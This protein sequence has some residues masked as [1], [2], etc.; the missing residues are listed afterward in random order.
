MRG[1]IKIL[2]LE[3]DSMDAELIREKLESSDLECLITQVQTRD[4]FS[5]ALH[6][7]G[8][9]LILSDYK[10]PM[11][12]GISAMQMAQEYCPD[13]PFIFVSGT[14]GE[15]AA[16]NTLTRGAT[17][18]VLKTRLNR[19][20]PAVK[21]AFQEI[22]S[23]RENMRLESIM[24][25]RFRIL[26][27]SYTKDLSL[28]ETCILVVD[29]IKALT[30]SEIG[31]FSFIDQARNA[32]VMQ[33][34]STDTTQNSSPID[35][36]NSQDHHSVSG[37]WTDCIN[38]GKPVIRNDYTPLTQTRDL[39]EGQINLFRE[40]L[41]PIIRSNS[42]VAGIGVANKPTDYDETDV[43]VISLLGDFSWELIRRKRL[44][45]EL[46]RSE[47]Q[48]RTLIDTIPDLVW[49][50][51]ADGVY[52]RCNRRF[53]SF[54][55]AKEKDIIGK[56]DYD[57]V[58]RDQADFFRSND[59]AAIIAGKSRMNE[60]KLTFLEDGH[61]EI[62][63]AIKTPVYTSQ[64]KLMGVLGVARDITR[65]IE[66]DQ[67]RLEHLQFFQCMDQIN[68]AMQATN[69]LEKMMINVLERTLSIFECDGASLIYPCDP[70]TE[71]WQVMQ[72]VTRPEYPG[73]GTKTP[74]QMTPDESENLRL[75]LDTDGPVQFGPSAGQVP[76]L[77]A[78][79]QETRTRSALV[80]AVFPKTGKPWQ[81]RIHQCSSER[82]WTSKEQRLFQEIGGRLADCL[83]T[84]LMYREV[85]LLLRE[86]HH[87]TKNIMAVIVSI[88]DIQSRCF[89]DPRWHKSINETKIQIKSIALV[90]QKLYETKELSQ[91]NL[92]DYLSDLIVILKSGYNLPAEHISVS[93]EMDDIF[94]EIDYA[95]PCGLIL[96]ELISNAY[97]YA[98]PG[99]R[100][101]EI[102][103]SLYRNEKGEI[104]LSV[105]DNGV[106][107]PPSFDFRNEA[108]LGIQIIIGLAEYQLG[109]NIR[110]E[111]DQ[112]L[113]CQ[114]IFSDNLYIKRI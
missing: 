28:D 1:H 11:F 33:S 20:A 51:D 95:V 3:D 10:L 77:T 82:I 17:D 67:E 86:L 47:A 56:T 69:D 55:G 65:R 72:E 54:F 37:L 89:S 100:K 36:R 43:Q 52:L 83:S 24:K 41:V 15:D 2:H 107:V 39:P 73:L 34:L 75:V 38:T 70:E 62:H 114:V 40:L 76:R 109:G 42:I 102:R 63:E 25:A 26:E 81:F 64:G 50:K 58:D 104:V 111:T 31:F 84:L 4:E 103:I 53:E 5:A 18:Y 23:R 106:G 22:S 48:L 113:S 96:N 105:A 66:A 92:K 90:H 32:M 101:G 44:E 98:F 46:R 87:R 93:S 59:R 97:K 35:L 91:I 88:L 112:G 60:E 13:I 61:T 9:D 57:F 94:V 78:L 80:M 68:R 45:D 29:E 49:L 74:I 85:Q 79:D 14:M 12:D 30:G 71:T 7:G 6:G 16:I 8:F 21:R 108:G 110:F 99:S 27:M 19:I